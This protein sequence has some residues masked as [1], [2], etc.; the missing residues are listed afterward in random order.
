MYRDQKV[1]IVMPGYN[2]QHTLEL[3]YEDVMAQDY[4]DLVIVVDDASHDETARIAHG[5]CKGSFPLGSST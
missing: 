3:T 4:V 5:Q 1:A 2:A